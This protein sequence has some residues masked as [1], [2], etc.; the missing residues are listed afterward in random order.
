MTQRIGLNI[1]RQRV[2]RLQARRGGI[3]DELHVGVGQTRTDINRRKSLGDLGGQLGRFRFGAIL[4]PQGFHPFIGQPQRRRATGTAGT[5]QQHAGPAGFHVQVFAEGAEDG[6]GVGIVS[7]Q[8][9]RTGERPQKA[10]WSPNAFRILRLENHGVHRSPRLGRDIQIIHHA[11]SQSFVGHREIHAA[12]THDPCAFESDGQFF[13]C[14]FTGEV[15]P[16]QVQRRQCGIV[17]GR[18][19]RMA[20]GSAPHRG[21]ARGGRD[22]LGHRLGHRGPE[23]AAKHR[24]R[25]SL[26]EG[27]AKPRRIR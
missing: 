27:F 26:F 16:I 24:W 2:F 15:P 10:D 22:R 13:G 9:H 7:P 19:R 23:S 3:E 25:P 14:D 11:Q 12:E 5:E 20:D 1:Q 6:V 8:P 21:Q 17:H 18:R 4:E